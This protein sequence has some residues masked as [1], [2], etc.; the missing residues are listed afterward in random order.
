MN[1]VRLGNSSHMSSQ[2]DG[3]AANGARKRPHPSRARA[4]RPGISRLSLKK[5]KKENTYWIIK[6]SLDHPFTCTIEFADCNMYWGA[7]KK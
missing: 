6:I 7:R 4:K 2:R 3:D 1:S 5:V